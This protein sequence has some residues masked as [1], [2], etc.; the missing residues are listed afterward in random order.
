MIYIYMEETL[1][2]I[3]RPTQKGK[4]YTAIVRDNE[5]KKERK[6]SFGSIDYPQFK[7]STSLKLYKSKDHGDNRRKRNYFKRHSSVKTKAEALSNEIAKS[8]GRYNAKILSH[9]FLW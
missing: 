6:I 1:V 4:K 9:R 2:K 3:I 8:G 7:D 5:T